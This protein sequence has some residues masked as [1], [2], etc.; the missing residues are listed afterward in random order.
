L[1]SLLLGGMPEF[2]VDWTEK[3]SSDAD[4]AKTVKISLDAMG[5]DAGPRMVVPGA[6]IALERRPDIRFQ[7][8]GNEAMIAPFLAEHPRLRETAEVHHCDVAVSMDAKPSQALKQ[9]RWR[10]SM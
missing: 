7:L 6:A 10:S 4:M 9:G 8:F 3:D 2:R 5:G 1:W